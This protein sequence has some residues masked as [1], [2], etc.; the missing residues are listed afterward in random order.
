MAPFPQPELRWERPSLGDL[1]RARVL[2]AGILG[3]DPGAAGRGFL[4]QWRELVS[5]LGAFQGTQSEQNSFNWVM[6]FAD[7][8]RVL[9][10]TAYNVAYW[11]LHDRSLRCRGTVG[12]DEPEFTVDVVS[13][14]VSS[15]GIL[16][17]SERPLPAADGPLVVTL[18]VGGAGMT[19]AARV[20]RAM[21]ADTGDRA[22]RTA[23]AFMGTSRADEDA[24]VR[25]VFER[26]RE[27]RRREA[28]LS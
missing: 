1:A 6:A 14:D 15:T 26:Q 10:D 24:L 13:E 25:F 5:G 27:L 22:W 18:P 23:L 8:V 3:I 28:G 4:V 11:N 2:N 12:L 20:V 17:R 16:V 9:R 7:D 19:L 21:R